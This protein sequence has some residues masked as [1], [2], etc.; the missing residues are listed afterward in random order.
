M[1]GCCVPG[2]FNSNKK[3]FSLR[4]FPANL[5]RR[6][7]WLGKI[8][9]KNWQ[10]S[11]RSYICE[12]HFSK[13]M[14]EKPR[15][16]GKQKLK[17]N[18]VPTIFP[19]SNINHCQELSE[20]ISNVHPSNETSTSVSKSHSLKRYADTLHDLEKNVVKELQIVTNIHETILM[21]IFK[22]SMSNSNN[23]SMNIN[24]Q[25]VINNNEYNLEDTQLTELNIENRTDIIATIPNS[26]A[27]QL[28]LQSAL[29]KIKNLETKLNKAN[30]IICK[31]EKA[32]KHLLQHDREKDCMLA[33]DK[34]SL[35]NNMTH[36]PI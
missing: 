30:T 21:D 22:K 2:C 16:D 14:W 9:K 34:M 20:T 7:L 36:Q 17:C 6:T 23:Q 5:E 26:D 12:I 8:G 33:L 13:D 11:Q 32:K 25:S 10:P 24:L 4:R 19:T 1:P 29:L 18:A 31:G 35:V 3:C 27:N 15:V 28:A